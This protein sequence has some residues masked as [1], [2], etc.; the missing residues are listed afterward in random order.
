MF[1]LFGKKGGSSEEQLAECC[2]KRD[3]A[4]LVKV[5]YRMGVEAMEAG[6]PYQAQLWLSRADT[7]YSADDSIYK[8]VGEKLMDDCSDRIGQLEDISTLYNDLPAQIEGMAANLNDVK[9][10]I[11]GLLS[12]A[13]L[14]KLGERLASLPGCE[15]FGK[16][17]WAVDMV[18]KSFQEPLS[19]ETFRGLQD[20]CGELYELG[21]SPA[22]WGEG[23]EIA[24]PGQAPFQVFDFNGMMGVHLEIDAYLDSHLKMM[25]ALGQGEE[26]GAPQTGII[27]G[28]LLPDYY[29][30]TGADIL[31]DVPGI[32]AELDRIWGDYEFIVGA[33]I[34]WELVSR[35]IAEYKEIKVP[36]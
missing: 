5:Y 32:K 4:G 28:A 2:R 11:W 20:L 18:L 36:V 34:S 33:D 25:S 9:I 8:K 6:N 7:I 16:L 35:K 14:V 21:D 15:V 29:V 31:T 19:E 22:F 12:L 3:W 1:H 10:R 27:V 13:R 24:V 17:G 23:N 30:R 26:P